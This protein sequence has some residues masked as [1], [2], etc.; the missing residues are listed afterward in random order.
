MSSFSL[1]HPN[2]IKHFLNATLIFVLLYTSSHK[3]T[4]SPL[5]YK[6]VGY[7]QPLHEYL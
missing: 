4:P 1:I 7:L 2:F 3:F 6:E 5:F